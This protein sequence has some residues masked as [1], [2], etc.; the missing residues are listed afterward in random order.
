MIIDFR[1]LIFD[2]RFSISMISDN[3]FLIIDFD[4]LSSILDFRFRIFD[5]KQ[6][7]IIK[8]TAKPVPPKGQSRDFSISLILTCFQIRH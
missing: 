1:L 3:R 8:R 4:F 5:L 2:F 7:G 6:G